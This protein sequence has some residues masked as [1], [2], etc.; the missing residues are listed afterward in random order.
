MSSKPV[1]KKVK[2]FN[3]FLEVLMMEDESGMD[4]KD[5]VI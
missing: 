3:K 5:A 2:K 1:T 4:E